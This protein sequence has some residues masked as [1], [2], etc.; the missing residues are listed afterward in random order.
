MLREIREIICRR[1]L[2]T[3]LWEL[4]LVHV[5]PFLR[6]NPYYTSIRGWKY[7][8][9][10][11]LLR[12]GDIILS[13]DRW[14]LL[15]FLVPGDFPH[16]TLCIA[17][18]PDEEFEVAEMTHLHYTKSTFFDICKEAD[19]VVILRCRDWDDAY[20]R[21]VIHT[22]MSFENA[23]YDP[24]FSADTDTLYCSQLVIASDPE[25]RLKVKPFKLPGAGT[26]CYSPTCILNA[27]NV[28]LIWD[29][30]NEI[31]TK[32]NKILKIEEAVYDSEPPPV[33]EEEETLIRQ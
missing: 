12:P 24:T 2:R 30:N 17:K 1:M 33:T 13:K 19:R 23:K 8:R 10:Y 7:T 11:R 21:T 20:I 15:S 27:E 5:M 16:A 26:E 29:S 18:G 22:C 28:T 14:K 4:L 25:K 6:L 32:H 3:K 9:G 31:Q